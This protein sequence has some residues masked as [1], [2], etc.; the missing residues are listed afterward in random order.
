MNLGFLKDNV[1]DNIS[2]K[3][4][5]WSELT[6]LYWGWKNLKNTKYAGLCHY[7]R[8]MNV[9]I[10]NENIDQLMKNYDMMVVDYYKDFDY[11]IVAKG[12]QS[13]LSQEDYW[14][15]IDTMLAMY[16][17]IKQTLLD[18]HYN[19]NTFVPYT[20]FV[21]RK[22]LYDEFCEFMFPVLFELEKRILPHSYNRQ[23]R[24]I[25]YFGEWTLGL[26]IAYKKLRV[27]KEELVLSGQVVHTKDYGIRKL[28]H[29]IRRNLTSYL[30]KTNI[31]QKEFSISPEILV[32]FQNDG[33]EL[34]G[35]K[36]LL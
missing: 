27:R 18:Y 36:N 22:E 24:I 13:A 21:A 5:Q 12:L 20:I 6:A 28:L 3:N 17:D 25:G 23:K 7:R 32:G 35:L 15:Y 1:G 19:N 16:P 4:P 8:Y 30:A 31:R 2:E 11:K 10:T 26:F 34:K 33:I 9:D 14:L 29:F